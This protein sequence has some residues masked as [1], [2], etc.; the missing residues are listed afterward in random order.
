MGY[1]GQAWLAFGHRR[2]AAVILPS[3][4]EDF[5]NQRPISPSGKRRG[6]MGEESIAPTRLLEIRQRMFMQNFVQA[7]S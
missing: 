5:F 6:L 7:R 1:G 2:S 4:L 3:I